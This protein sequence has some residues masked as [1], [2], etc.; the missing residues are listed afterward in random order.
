ATAGAIAIGQ[1]ADDGLEL[2]TLQVTIDPGPADPGPQLVKSGIEAGI[3][4]TAELRDDLLGED[5]ERLVGDD[6]LVEL[7]TPDT[8]NQCGAF[9]QIIPGQGKQYALG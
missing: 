6:Q 9:H 5:V 3:L 4:E 7:T 2:T 1:H 8:V